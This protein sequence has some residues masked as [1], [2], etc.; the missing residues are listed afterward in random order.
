MGS[1]GRKYGFAADRVR[2]VEIVTA[3]GRVRRVTAAAE[4]EL[5]W[6]VRGGKGNFGI[7]TALEFELVPVRSVYGGGIFFTGNDASAVLHA[8]RQWAPTMP[9]EVATSVAIMRMPPMDMVPP[10]LRGKTVVHLRYSYCGADFDE[11][12]RLLAPMRATG[13]I[14]LGFVGPMLTTEMD[15]IHM[16][17]VDPMP[18]WE[19]GTLLRE[20]SA[21]TVD[22]LLAAAGPQV[23]IPLVM[24]E[25]RL[26][27]GALA[28]QPESPNAVAGRS[29]AYSAFAVA[30]LFPELAEIVPMVGRGVLGALQ[31]WAS[32]ECMVNFLGDVTG[33]EE[34]AAAYP[35]AVFDRLRAV[36][37]DVDPNGVFRFGHAF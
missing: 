30:P 18:F 11:A 10:P 31:P 12:E 29:A 8:F 13:E 25:V 17:P 7:V 5:F 15:G 36:K 26:L 6:A 35:P 33:P 28:R 4:P 1:L 20:L 34:V 14:L 37:Q 22:A 9:E 23:E 16:D 32:S 24:L 3:D 2:A 19:K 21:E 27:G